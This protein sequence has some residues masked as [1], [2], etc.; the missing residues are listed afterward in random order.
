MPR[1]LLVSVIVLLVLSIGIILTLGM[2]PAGSMLT[3][4]LQIVC[5][6]FAA[7]MCFS[8]SKR[9]RGLSR[10]F[11]ILVGCSIATWGVANL[12]WM[13]YENW[14]HAPVPRFSAVRILFDVQGVFYAIAL[15][16]DKEKD[17]PEFNAEMV[18]DSVQ[19]AIVFLSLFFGLFYAQ[20]LQGSQG[21]FS[22]LIVTWI[23]VGVNLTLTVL[24]AVQ[25]S[26]AKSERIR[27]LYRGLA[28][29]LLIYT[30][31]S[32]LAESS[33]ANKLVLT[34]NLYD[35]GWTIPFLFAVMW[36][37]RWQERDEIAP[38]GASPSKTLRELALKNVMLAL[39]PLIVLVL[40]ARLGPQWRMIGFSLLAVS[41]VSYVVRLGITEFRQTQSAAAVMRHR[42][43]MESTEDGMAILDGNGV[44]VYANSAFAR[45][46]GLP[47]AQ[48]VLGKT[49]QQVYDP[50]DVA[51]LEAEVRASV[52]RTGKWS[53]Q[54]AL[55]RADNTTLPI[56]MT[57]TLM[58]PD[59]TV[60]VARDISDRLNAEHA[61][62]EAEIKYRTLVE[63][64][65][66][67]SYIAQIGVHAQWLYV[68]PQVETI[69]GYS[70]DEWLAE[71]CDWLRHIPA[72][73]HP[74]VISAEERSGRGE[75]FQAEYRMTR[76]D[77]EIIWVSDNAV[78]V[79]GSDSHP[80]MEGLIVDITDRKLLENQL[81][82][83]RKMEA[84]GRLAGGVAHDFN[85]LLTIIKGY[86]EMALQRCLDRPELHN[87]I[88]RIEEAADRAVTLVRQLLA[89]SRK[90]VLRPKILDLNT[91]VLNLDQ[92]LRRLMGEN[93]EMKTFVSKDVG[94]IK[95]DPGQ[96]EQVIMNLVVNARDAL[97]DGGHILI[98]TSNVDLDSTY[99]RDHAVVVPGRYVLL[100]VTDTG[101]GMTADTVA[102]IFEPFYT[103]KESGRGTGL[104]L[105]TVYG[106]VKQSGGYI[107]VY[108]ELGKGT[109]FKVYLPRVEEAVPISLPPAVTPAST[110]RKGH[111]T[112]LLVEDEP[113]LRELTQMVLSARGYT[114][115][116]ASTPAEAERLAA[117]NGAE[118]HLLLT[119][120]VMPGI[121]GG[122]L[123][124][125]LTGRYPNLR[126]LFMSGY[127]YNV[128]AQ[129]GTLEEGISFLQKPFTPQLLTEKVREALDRPVSVK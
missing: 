124:K 36:A 2:S 84:V 57:I 114:V 95:A 34:G 16:L 4:L 76:K 22:E 32:G 81:Q 102:H 123:A 78:V 55:H 126:V 5:C 89:F 117:N 51:Q 112:I 115:I 8:A 122:E 116:E 13:Y 19:I 93:I 54:I 109:T 41:I 30:L 29:F 42:V 23:F 9:G 87:D 62:A 39:A 3:N 50:R 85:N 91:I 104:G 27:S 7:A 21:Q 38:L 107:W 82:Q 64:V 26:S 12:G 68:S 119:D 58:A 111:E 15:F 121:S 48:A 97:P 44:H 120:V 72:E 20:V 129:D 31:G 61:R 18:L 75:P 47:S 108:S 79:R 105:S 74:I 14:L 103:T 35:L 96:I 65:A 100:A 66:A 45:M 49:W 33:W 127:T 52:Q 113:D 53:G 43:A 28:L 69:L 98:E 25:M 94:A 60:C 80:V 24:A 17:S 88:R 6:G 71:S 73:D 63:Q 106:I 46:V 56:E 10:P 83:A 125:R 99:T 1:K 11:W 37:G 101:I 86:L 59:G 70:P 77:G 67:I 118:I 110:A 92:L 90:Q 40:V 128:F